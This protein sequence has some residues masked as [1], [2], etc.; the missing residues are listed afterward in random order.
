MLQ[1]AS[2][3]VLPALMSAVEQSGVL[4]TGPEAR[5]IAAA[6]AAVAAV[7][8]AVEGSHSSSSLIESDGES[9]TTADGSLEEEEQQQEA[10]ARSKQT[11]RKTGSMPDS[12]RGSP[13]RTKSGRRGSAGAGTSTPAEAASDQQPIPE[14]K[15]SRQ[16]QSIAAPSSAAAGTAAGSSGAAAGAHG[17]CSALL[18]THHGPQSPSGSNPSF[19][20]RSVASNITTTTREGLASGKGSSGAMSKALM[21]ESQAAALQHQHQHQHQHQQ[22]AVRLVGISQHPHGLGQSLRRHPAYVVDE[23]GR[24]MDLPGQPDPTAAARQ[25]ARQDSEGS[26]PFAP[27]SHMTTGAI[28]ASGRKLT[29]AVGD[30]DEDQEEE[31]DETAG[32]EGEGPSRSGSRCR[33]G[34]DGADGMRGEQDSSPS[35]TTSGGSGHAEG[36]DGVTS[37]SSRSGDG[38][39]QSSSGRAGRGSDEGSSA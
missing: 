10:L 2:T 24:F 14:A 7:S 36:L 28:A 39:E 29:G 5:R 25:Q 13:R 19:H 32:A 35:E 22:Q 37:G 27:R 23:V 12:V 38:S 16:A 15:R 21:A 20:G 9:M 34:S 3:R 1:S 8:A 31:D 11:Q 6:N 4:G 26:N 18:E 33:G 17:I 30:R